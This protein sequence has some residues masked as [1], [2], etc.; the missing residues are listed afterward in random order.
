MCGVYLA[1]A[2]RC[3]SH[4]GM[5]TAAKI[6]DTADHCGHPSRCKPKADSVMDILRIEVKTGYDALFS[7]EDNKTYIFVTEEAEV[8]RI[9]H[10]PAE[11]ARRAIKA[12]HQYSV[13]HKPNGEP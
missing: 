6:I 11:E 4:E 10:L 13:P 5:I 9:L 3:P 7:E 2:S 12:N 1:S 8:K